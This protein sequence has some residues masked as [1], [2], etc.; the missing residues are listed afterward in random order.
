M[1]EPPAV[2]AAA[3][4]PGPDRETLKGLSVDKHSE[5][6]PSARAELRPTP[7]TDTAWDRMAAALVDP[8]HRFTPDQ[9]IYLFSLGLGWSSDEMM[10][11]SG[12][13]AGRRSVLDEQNAAYPPP[14]VFVAGDWVTEGDRRLARREADDVAPREGDHPGGPVEWVDDYELAGCDA[15]AG[16]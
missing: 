1:D 4:V 11:H 15:G 8:K 9:M 3:G 5:T 16:R 14:P 10:W 7:D 12:Y 13:E 6:V 2:V